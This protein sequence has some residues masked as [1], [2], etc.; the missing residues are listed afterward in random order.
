MNRSKKIIILCHCLLN[1]NAKITPL[2]TC[3]GVYK[4][5]VA[6]YIADGVGLVQLPCPESGYLG[7]NRWGMTRDQYNTLHFRK[8]C[9]EILAPSLNQ[10]KAFVDAGYE[11]QG[12]I[13]M[14]G[15]PNCGV[16]ETCIGFTGG[17]IC[18]QEDIERQRDNMSMVP[19]RGVF[20]EVLQEMLLAEEISLPFWAVDERNIKE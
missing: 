11:I 10:I 19:G 20:F 2:A 17:E 15:S 1:S 8:Y 18:C 7:Q 5:V 14:D 9:R 3:G 13:G 4:S 6:Q 16:E 12:V